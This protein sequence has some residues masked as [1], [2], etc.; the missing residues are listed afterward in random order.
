MIDPEIIDATPVANTYDASVS[1]VRV[2]LG[3]EKSGRGRRVLTATAA[4]VAAVTLATAAANSVPE[5]K[6]TGELVNQ[7]PQLPAD[8]RI[9]LR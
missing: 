4:A 8:G 2:D 1:P 6:H 9:I 5:P 3:P 7:Q